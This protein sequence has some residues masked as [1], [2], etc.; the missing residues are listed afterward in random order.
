[1]KIVLIKV[2]DK[3]KLVKLDKICPL[4]TKLVLKNQEIMGEIKVN[5]IKQFH[6]ILKP[7]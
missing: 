5:N 2:M 3:D 7:L 4:L 6:I 1:M